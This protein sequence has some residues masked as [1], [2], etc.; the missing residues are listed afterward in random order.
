MKLLA[1]IVITL[2]VSGG[3]YMNREIWSVANYKSAV[4]GSQTRGL[5]GSPFGPGRHDQEGIGGHLGLH[6]GLLEIL[7]GNGT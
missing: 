6:D 1:P 5:G 2:L 7:G 3:L 4:D